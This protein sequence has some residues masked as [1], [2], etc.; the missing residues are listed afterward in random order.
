MSNQDA[1]NELAAMNPTCDACKRVAEGKQSCCAFHYT[2][3]IDKIRE[4]RDEGY[5]L[6]Q[7]IDSLERAII[8]DPQIA[9]F[10][11]TYEDD[12]QERAVT[13]FE[14]SNHY[15]EIKLA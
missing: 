11:V 13:Q 15:R 1:K 6:R 10:H 14:T 2:P 5:T 9:H 7:L 3:I 8:L 4:R 12:C